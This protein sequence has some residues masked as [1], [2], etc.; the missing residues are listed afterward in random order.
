MCGPVPCAIHRPRKRK[1]VDESQTYELEFIDDSGAGRTIL[2]QRAL[3]EQ[4]I[5]KYQVDQYIGPSSQP[6]TFDTGGGEKT[7]NRSIGLTGGLLQG[8]EAYLLEDSPIAI[9][10]GN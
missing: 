7:S 2:S 3:T 1:Q 9:P 4:G 5:P 6:I 8:T 10:W